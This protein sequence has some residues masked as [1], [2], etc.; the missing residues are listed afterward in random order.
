M[1][2]PTLDSLAYTA[3]KKQT[4]RERFLAEMEQVV[5]LIAEHHPKSGKAGRPPMSPEAMLRIHFLRQWYTLSD[6]AM[7]DALYEIE[8]M[9]RFSGLELNVNP[10]PDETN[11]LKF[12][13]FLEKHALAPRILQ[14]MN[15]HLAAR[16]M[17]M[18]AGTL[19]D[20]TIGRPRKRS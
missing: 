1:N 18:R 13:R 12:R 10:I 11:I 2:Q 5:A 9:Q 3:K 6:P 17:Q 15:A 14:A 19:V 7:E 16:G 20:P 8:S 4:R